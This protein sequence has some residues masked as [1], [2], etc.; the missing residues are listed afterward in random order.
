[1][2]NNELEIERK[3]LVLNDSW[4]S[5]ITQILDIKQ[6]YLP[7]NKRIRIVDSKIAFI[8]EKTDIDGHEAFTKILSPYL[9]EAGVT[10]FLNNWV[11]STPRFISAPL[12]VK[13]DVG[14]FNF[15]W[16][17]MSVE[18]SFSVN[19]SNLNAVFELPE[20]AISQRYDLN[21]KDE[22]TKLAKDLK[23]NISKPLG[24]KEV[25]YEINLSEGL[26]LIDK[27]EAVLHKTRHI[28]PFE[29]K[30]FEVDVFNNLNFELVMAEI[31]LNSE[32]EEVRIPSWA[33]QEVSFDKE[34]KNF[35]L[36]KNVKTDNKIKT[37]KIN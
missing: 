9:K 29:G 35:Q 33:G 27:S 20:K 28:V 36:I 6:A 31:E 8:T 16:K 18:A 3:F 17:T 30:N 15:S 23:N 13:L 4:K 12:D 7:D 34:Y 32:N 14:D 25:E 11:S 37:K 22:W 5:S 19:L 10:E 21:D 24:K 2:N 26:R 1:M